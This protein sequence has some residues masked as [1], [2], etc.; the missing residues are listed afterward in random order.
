MPDSPGTLWGPLILILGRPGFYAHIKQCFYHSSSILPVCPAT[1]LPES[2]FSSTSGIKLTVL[3]AQ[4]PGQWWYVLKHLHAL[5]HNSQVQSASSHIPPAFG[6][7]FPLQIDT[8]S[9]APRE[10]EIALPT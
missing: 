5:I 7:R 10:V 1:S 3:I 6:P 2:V 8:Q 9:W 4:C